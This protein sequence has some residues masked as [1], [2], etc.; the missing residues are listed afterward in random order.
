MSTLVHNKQ[1]K[2]SPNTSKTTDV[3]LN[4]RLIRVLCR[5]IFSMGYR[6]FS[7]DCKIN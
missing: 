1:P 3:Q 6:Y 2:P 5:P 4:V 7:A